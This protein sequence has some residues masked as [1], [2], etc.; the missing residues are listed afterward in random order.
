MDVRWLCGGKC[1]VKSAGRCRAFQKFP[2][3][4]PVEAR[5][6]LGGARY[7]CGVIAQFLN[8]RSTFNTVRESGAAGGH[9]SCQKP[10]ALPF[11]G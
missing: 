8:P 3:P 2:D 6:M 11:P 9:R 1:E 10:L 5:V 4:V 7:K